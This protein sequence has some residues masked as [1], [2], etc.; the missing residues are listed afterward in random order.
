MVPH[1]WQ[2]NTDEC[3]G[4]NEVAVANFIQYL[5]P[6]QWFDGIG[7]TSE[8]L[9]LIFELAVYAVV[10]LLVIALIRKCIWPLFRWTF[11]TSSP[12]K[13]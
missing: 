4:C 5:N 6:K 11:C 9:A 12:K 10:V 13:G 3:I 8:S 2:T 7:S 1:R